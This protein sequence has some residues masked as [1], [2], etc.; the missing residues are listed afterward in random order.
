METIKT[1]LKKFQYPYYVYREIEKKKEERVS[2]LKNAIKQFDEGTAK[3]GSLTEYKRALYRQRFLYDEYDAYRLW[4]LDEKRWN[5]FISEREIQCIYRK[6]VQVNVGMCFT[7]KMKELVVFKKFVHR[8]WMDP[9]AV[10]YDAFKEFVTSTKCIAKPRG[11]RQGK[12]VFLVQKGDDLYLS[13]LYKFCCE[14][15][16]LVEE[17]MRACKE[18]EEFHPN[19]LNS[20]RV[21][22][23][24]KGD[25]VELLDAEF[26]MGVRDNVV[27]NAHQGG[28]LASI[29]IG[30]G[31]LARNGVDLLGN[32]YATHPDTGKLIK[33]FVIPH[34]NDIV[35]VCMEAATVIPE[36]V[37]AGWD[38]CV[39][40]NGEIELIEV[41]AFPGVTGLQASSQRG[42]KPRLKE[43]GERVLGFNPL[44]L[45]SVWSKS[46]VKYERKYGYYY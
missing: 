40:Q 14:S 5:E 34:W 41:N 24:S 8:K 37:F 25:K 35:K 39:R 18:I 17:Y 1:K 6:I 20:V 10:S 30:T 2:F 33:G 21:L 28:I 36:T 15:H 45:I 23:I 42:L 13:Q 29:D 31:M 26:R 27:D 22:T 3:H 32:E 44:K 19:S 7:D 12:G 9:N 43:A 4:D 11:G 46:Y 38:V 16:V